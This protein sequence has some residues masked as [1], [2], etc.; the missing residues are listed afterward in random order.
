MNAT[1][2]KLSVRNWAEEDRPSYKLQNYGAGSLTDAELISLL[3]GSGTAQYN[4]VEIANHILCKFDRDLSKLSKAE[5]YE[6]NEVEGVGS[7]TICK[8][9]AAMELGKRRQMAGC[10]MPPDLSSAT[11]I[12]RYMLPKMQD[13]KIEEFWVLLCNQ[14][15]KLIKPVRIS[16]GGITETSVDI[17]IIMKQAVLANAT[18]SADE[19]PFFRP[20]DCLR[21]PV[22]FVCR[23]GTAVMPFFLCLASGRCRAGRSRVLRLL[24]MGRNL[25]VEPFCFARKEVSPMVD[26][27]LPLSLGG[28]RMA[29]EDVGRNHYPLPLP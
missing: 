19:N 24:P 17:R 8:L 10:P 13:L 25:R 27:S 29:W 1:T 11:A 5:F 28:L 16:Q 18:M 3:V 12:Y 2:V 6:L 22:L 4:A 14:N 7:Q 23:E 21:R 20:C 26:C 15:Y 9:M